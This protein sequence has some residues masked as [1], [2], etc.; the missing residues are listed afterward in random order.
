MQKLTAVK[1]DFQG[2]SQWFITSG[3]KLLSAVFILLIGWWV[4]KL[5]ARALKN[6]L[7]KSKISPGAAGFIGSVVKVILWIIAIITALGQ[8]EINLTSLIT[9]LGAA[10]LTASFAL[11]GSLG[12]FVSGMQVIFSKPFGVGDFLSVETYMGTVKTID[13][14]NTTLVTPDNKEIVIPNS[15]M[16]SGIVVNFTSQKSRRLDLAYWVSYDTDTEKPK[17]ILKTMIEEDGRVLTDPLPII[18][19]G[20]YGPSG[21]EIVAKIWCSAEEYWDVYYHMQENVKKAFQ[22]AGIS[23]PFPQ[24]DVHLQER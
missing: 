9:A 21:V 19:V 18:A 6:I 16:T 20:E 4:A 5:A 13:V 17:N 12:N 10:G 11:Q 1:F 22:S 24:M 2:V 3:L 14:L 23:F 15:M 7:L 8:F